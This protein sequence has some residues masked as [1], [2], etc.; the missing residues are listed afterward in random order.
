MLIEAMAEWNLSA[1]DDAEIAGLVARC[2]DTD[3]GGRSYFIQRHH[4]RLIHRQGAI[5]GHTAL[6]LRAVEL[7][8]RR[9]TIAGLAEVATDPAFRRRGIAAALLKEAILHAKASPA[10][11]LLLFG[12]AK[13]YAAFGFCAV[14]NKLAHVATKGDR[15]ARIV[16]DGHDNLMVLAL[17][18]QPWPQDETLDLRGPVF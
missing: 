17:R 18:D 6:T 4:L 1:H 14:S 10:E 8:E 9:L 5:I 15:V 13:L 3:F 16:T 11:H 2:F 12:T 7:G